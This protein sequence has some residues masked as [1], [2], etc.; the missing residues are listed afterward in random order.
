MAEINH[1]IGIKGSSKKVYEAL[2]RVSLLS[3]WWTTD[4]RGDSKAGGILHFRFSGGGGPDMKVL[5]TVPTRKVKW[6]CISGPDEWIGTELC[7]NLKETKSGTIVLFKHSRWKNT[8]PFLAHCSSKWG[9][10]MLSLKDLI[11]DDK[12]RPFPKDI[13]ITFEDNY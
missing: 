1:R 9:T 4:T 10:F 3:R 7:F 6:S 12:G 2:T 11:E 13:E 8:T 5:E